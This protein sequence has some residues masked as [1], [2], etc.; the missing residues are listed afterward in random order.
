[1]QLRFLSLLGAQVLLT[2][3]VWADDAQVLPQGRFRARLLTSYTQMDAKYD[4]TGTPR[5]LGA[6]FSRPMTGK[7]LQS[8][9]QK[10]PLSEAVQKLA[11]INSGRTLETL[12]ETIAQTEVALENQ[13]IANA[14]VLEYG[15]TSQISLGI[16]L[17][18]VWAEAHV[19]AS[20]NP[21]EAF[22]QKTSSLSDS[23]PWKKMRAGLS[24]AASLSA[25]NAALRDQLGYT[26]GIRSWSGWGLGDLELGMKY[27][28]YKAH[29]LQ[30]TLKT[31]ARL[32]TGRTDDP[33]QIFD[34]PFGDG[35]VD[36]A[37]YH[38]LDYH[39][40][41]NLY[42]TWELGYTYQMPSSVD[43]RIPL[44]ADLPLGA[45][46]IELDRKLGDYWETSLEANV[47]PAKRV[48]LSARYRFKQKF[49]DS[50]TGGGLD[51]RLLEQDTQQVLHE[52]QFIAEYSN[53]SAVRAGTESVPY[54]ISLFYRM[55]LGGENLV[56]TRTTGLQLKTYF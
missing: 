14:F 16:I 1:M 27:N 33:N 25:L 32:P 10:S 38:Y 39:I 8:L 31:G 41:G 7:F 21:S 51:T 45:Q 56:D 42:L 18:V 23:D 9:V 43:V 11:Q 35:Q 47:A 3:Q 17:P 29:P 2:F 34:I 20:S 26:D 36:L 46:T 49:E 15:L 13:M 50:Y 48:L 12:N 5:S 54:A 24:Q 6:S 52:T 4:S 28:F 19:S 30:A 55:P 22:N 44:Q 40:L 37:A 53:L